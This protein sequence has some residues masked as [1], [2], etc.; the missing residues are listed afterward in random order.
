M[1]Q[2]QLLRGKRILV[3]GG[4]S[5]LG[6]EISEKY[7]E[8]GAEVHICGRRQAVLE[9]AAAALMERHGG[10]VKTHVTD[11]RSA[12]AVDAM[13]DA[14]WRDSGPLDGLVNNAAGNFVSRTQDV[15]PRGFDAVANTVLHGTYYMTHHVGRRWIAD[16]HKGSVISIVVTWVRTGAPF[17]VPSAM[18]KAGID[19]MTKSLAIEWG[20][21]GIRLNAIAP[22]IFP[23]EGANKRLSPKAQWEDGVVRNPMNRLGRMS[24]LQNLAVFLM[25]DGVDWINGETIAIDGAGHRQN[26]AS[27]TDL[28]DLDD[29][30]WREMREAIR[31]QDQR[32][33]SLR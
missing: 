30:A 11:V 22:G 23:T 4:G 15:S 7:L 32:D 6:R 9:E 20:R 26:G 1:F 8:L 12:E 21:Y 31:N 18:S 3:T 29:A 17:V 10:T 33:K 25:A 16:G 14:I 24:E 13:V 2:A 5:G 27:F 28:A 19:V